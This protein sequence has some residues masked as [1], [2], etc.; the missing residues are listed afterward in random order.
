MGTVI[1]FFL[2]FLNLLLLFLISY[3][4]LLSNQRPL[5]LYSS[6]HS[7]MIHWFLS[8]QI[9]LIF[10]ATCLTYLN[11][12]IYSSWYFGLKLY[13]FFTRMRYLPSSCLSL[14]KYGSGYLCI[15][16]VIIVKETIDYYY[17][18]S[19]Q[20]WLIMLWTGVNVIE[21]PCLFFLT[22]KYLYWISITMNIPWSMILKYVCLPI[23]LFSEYLPHH[24]HSYG[25]WSWTAYCIIISYCC[26]HD[27]VANFNLP[28]CYIQ[29]LHC[30]LRWLKQS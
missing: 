6:S 26:Q 14:T 13:T 5:L 19:I 23:Y 7:E 8:T 2:S 3:H 20:S 27:G 25:N 1:L 22:W 16:Q 4:P 15:M 30:L 10:S 11:L 18:L 12:F 28:C 24:C 17:R 9:Y 29:I 21:H